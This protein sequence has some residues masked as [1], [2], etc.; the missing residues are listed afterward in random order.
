MNVSVVESK[1]SRFNAMYDQSCRINS[2]LAYTQY[3]LL[4]RKNDLNTAIKMYNRAAIPILHNLK[5][6]VDGW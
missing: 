4:K 1:V 5:K 6:S 2:K 3:I